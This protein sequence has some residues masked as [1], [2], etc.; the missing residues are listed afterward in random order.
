MRRYKAILIAIWAACSPLVFS[1]VC[2]TVNA[3]TSSARCAST[4]AA[5]NIG[6]GVSGR[7][8][9]FTGDRVCD[10]Q[11]N[12]SG[13]PPPPSGPTG[14]VSNVLT[15]PVFINLYWDSNWDDDNPT[16]T[17]KEMD[18][19]TTAMVK[20][21]YF[22]GLSE[23][24]VQ[25]AS[26]GGSFLPDSRCDQKA[27]SSVG[28]Y[29]PI[30]SSITG[31]LDCELSHGNLATGDQVVYNIILPKGSIESDLFGAS[32]F[33]TG[34]G[35]K[36]AWHFHQN[37]FSALGT[38]ALVAGFA[39][40]GSAGAIAA[41]LAAMAA[42]PGGPIYTIT[43]ADPAC[44]ALTGNMMHEMVEAT[45]DPFVT[46]SVILQGGEGEIADLAENCSPSNPFVPPMSV[47]SLAAKPAFPSSAQFTTSDIISV[48]AYWSNAKRKCVSGSDTTTPTGLNITTTGNGAA[49][50]MTISG[51][52]FGTLPLGGATL[53]YIA[54]QNETQVWQAGNSL[55]LDEVGLNV[56]SWTNNSITVN[57]F[58]FTSGN[59]IMM[60]GDHLTVWVCNPQSG[61][62]GSNS[63]LLSESGEPELNVMVYN[64]RE[65]TLTYEVKID[66]T[67][68]AAS[69]GDGGSTGWRTEIAGTHAVSELSTKPGFYNPVF[70][71][72][73]NAAGSIALK[74]GDNQV[75]VIVNT[76]AT[77]CS[78][79]QHCC[80]DVNSKF[81][82]VAGCVSKAVACQPLCPFGTN[83]CCGKPLPDGKCDSACVNSSIQACQ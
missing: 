37:P 52:G 55:N 43:S 58:N 17:R 41:L 8:E 31:F 16:M 25:S 40:G 13:T 38:G 73:C 1:Q 10:C 42:V 36:D 15:N 83:K 80:G 3:G 50:T 2:R 53:P 11:A 56:A 82:C 7:C 49:L 60:P 71:S 69:L 79:D 33:C 5:C 9:F 35:G 21:S 26:F 18:A 32:S 59:L 6:G 14:I 47:R 30:G 72:G 54:I 34:S 29:S 57:G 75:C 45:T 62:C 74:K 28:F 70:H 67:E 66:G 12:S 63:I 19:F 27:P 51:A 22:G 64:E 65:V 23:Y 39:T 77:G 4:G 76:P 24:G 46:P 20:S 81:G 44:H 48:P 78:A 68:V 61:N